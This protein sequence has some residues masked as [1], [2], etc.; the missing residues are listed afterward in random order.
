MEFQINGGKVF[1][2]LTLV[3]R[4]MVAW[5]YVKPFAKKC[6]S[7]SVFTALHNHYLGPKNVNNQDYAAEYVLNMATYT[8][9]THNWNFEKYANLPKAAWESR[10]FDGE[11]I[12]RYLQRYQG[13]PSYDVGRSDTDK[14]QMLK[15]SDT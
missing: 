13:L 14:G 11:W 3:R 10:G 12:Q 4:E 2:A 6:N 9:E 7:C 5:T 8:G 1:D 15:E